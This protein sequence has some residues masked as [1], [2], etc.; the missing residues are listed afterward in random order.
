MR[1]VVMHGYLV[2]HTQPRAQLP[3]VLDHFDLWVSLQPFSRC[4]VCNSHVIQ[5]EKAGVAALV[6]P[7]TALHCDEFWRCAGR[8]SVYW[9]GSHYRSLEARL[10]EAANTAKRVGEEGAFPAQRLPQASE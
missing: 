4:T 1:S 5:V 7:R 2:R 10:V 9:K 3:E 8:G 6:P